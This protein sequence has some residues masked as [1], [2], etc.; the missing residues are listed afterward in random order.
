[1]SGESEDESEGERK[2]EGDEVLTPSVENEAVPEEMQSEGQVQE[3]REQHTAPATTTLTSN[4]EKMKPLIQHKDEPSLEDARQNYG[5]ADQ[6]K[7][8]VEEKEEL[9][10]KEEGEDKEWVK[11]KGDTERKEAEEEKEEEKEEERKE[12]MKERMEE[13][14][15][16]EKEELERKEE[17][18]DKEWVKVKGDTERKEAEEETA[19]EKEEERKEH[20]KE[21]MEEVEEEEE[22][23]TEV[24]SSVDGGKQKREEDEK[25]RNDKSS[26]YEKHEASP[27][28]AEEDLSANKSVEND[29]VNHE[30]ANKKVSI[31]ED[32]TTI[33]PI[34]IDFPIASAH[35][36][37][38]SAVAII[39]SPKPTSRDT[40]S[41]SVPKADHLDERSRLQRRGHTRAASMTES[42]KSL[43]S[44]VIGGGSASSNSKIDGETA[45]SKS[46]KSKPKSSPSPS[47]SS[48]SESSSGA[49]SRHHS[50]SEK[51][52]RSKWG[53]VRSLRDQRE[54]DI[55]SGTADDLLT[56][57]LNKAAAALKGGTA[58]AALKGGTA[59]ADRPQLLKQSSERLVRELSICMVGCVKEG[60]DQQRPEDAPDT[61]CLTFDSAVHVRSYEHQEGASHPPLI[62]NVQLDPT[63]SLWHVERGADTVN[64]ALSGLSAVC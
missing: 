13:V 46:G 36:G 35:R 49:S 54:V 40:L 31:A 27:A 6:E 5:G 50:P 14:E 63:D 2:G 57:K 32:V 23:E 19:E 15:E 38:T 28:V 53:R 43:K 59:P 3:E 39:S 56:A 48:S 55:K 25:E 16:E 52:K 20:M 17:G 44:L 33:P 58:P 61:R 51:K 1:V 60:S 7:E 4:E 11:V 24:I 8:R 45:S 18:E 62:N 26:Q 64:P 30:V 12:H 29:Q 21:R 47:P 22:E 37:A 41:V 42:L 34:T 10:R 9:E